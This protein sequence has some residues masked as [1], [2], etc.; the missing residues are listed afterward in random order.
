VRRIQSI[1]VFCRVIDHFGDAAFSWRLSCALKN[2]GVP[3]VTLIIDRPE[4]LLALHQADKLSTISRESGVRVLTWEEAE[5]RWST[6]GFADRI[7]NGDVTDLDN[8]SDIVIETF[9]CE[10]PSS[11]I[12]A[13]TDYPLHTD[14]RHKGRL[15]S[16]GKT[17]QWF[18]LD[19]LATEPWADEAHARY[20][21]SPR[22][23]GP[24]AQRR[25]W[26][27]PGFSTRTGGL[28][29]GS[30]RHID[31]VR[32]R[33]WRA[34]IAGKT[35]PDDCFLVLG[36]GYEDA[37]WQVLAEALEQD[38]PSGFKSFH[39]WRP[40]DLEVSQSQFDEV[41][42]SCDLNFVRGEDSFIRAHWAAAGRWQIPLVWQPYRQSQGAHREKLLGWMNQIIPSDE[43]NAL[44]DFHW[45]WNGFSMPQ[46][47]NLWAA[48]QAFSRD[49]RVVK[50]RLHQRCHQLALEP[51]LESEILREARLRL[52]E[53][54]ANNPGERALKIEN[55]A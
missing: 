49:Y 12:Q 8:L 34:H 38:L 9:A 55:R 50:T 2:C 32:R 20:S 30:W 19:Y 35:I 39:V 29:H 45:I 48:W 16:V 41:L 22:H 27:I 23:N 7:D 36:F 51:S 17:V 52:V 3:S 46:T 44:R 1:T 42:Q 54:G 11:Y 15:N 18:T 13:L 53:M 33:Y 25:R 6:E 24:I 4:V 37:P 40:Q 14:R 10:P 28:L 26:L 47:G 5:E 43:F 21:P 31:E